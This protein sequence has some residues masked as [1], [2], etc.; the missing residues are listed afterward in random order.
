MPHGL[1]LSDL[2]ARTRGNNLRRLL[3]IPLSQFTRAHFPDSWFP[4]LIVSWRCAS[5]DVCESPG[6]R[7]RI[8][9]RQFEGAELITDK[10]TGP[11]I[12]RDLGIESSREGDPPPTAPLDVLVVRYFCVCGLATIRSVRVPISFRGHH[13]IEGIATSANNPVFTEPPR[14]KATISMDDF[15]VP[16]SVLRFSHVVYGFIPMTM[17][18]GLTQSNQSL[19]KSHPSASSQVAVKRQGR[20]IL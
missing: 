17:N 13:T 3:V 18:F 11:F 4:R 1:A 14:W 9:P 7:V 2:A 10:N 12:T 5:A 6:S 15:R 8:F 16:T 19:V 20:Q